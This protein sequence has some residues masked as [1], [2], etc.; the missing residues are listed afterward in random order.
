MVNDNEIITSKIQKVKTENISELNLE[1]KLKKKLLQVIFP[2]VF[3]PSL[4]SSQPAVHRENTQPLGFSHAFKSLHC[5][6]HGYGAIT[7]PLRLKVLLMT[8]LSGPIN[9]M[10]LIKDASITHLAPLN[11]SKRKCHTLQAHTAM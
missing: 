3:P 6:C 10:G 9:L 7:W 11:I 4:V 5:S 1:F 2:L 8:L